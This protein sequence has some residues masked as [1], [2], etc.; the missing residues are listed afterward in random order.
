MVLNGLIAACIFIYCTIIISSNISFIV[1]VIESMVMRSM[2]VVMILLIL[3]LTLDS[4]ITLAFH[5]QM[6]I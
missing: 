3:H 6:R 5:L 2:F 1:V 4:R